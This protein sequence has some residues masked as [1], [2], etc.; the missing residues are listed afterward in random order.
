MMA[1]GRVVAVFSSFFALFRLKEVFGNFTDESRR[2][3][4]LC[5]SVDHARFCR[6]EPGFFF[7]A[8]QSHVHEASFF[9]EFGR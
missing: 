5:G 8:R 3:V 4:H 7:G 1:L 9:F 6:D 2:G